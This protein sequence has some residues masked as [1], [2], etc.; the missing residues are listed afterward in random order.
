[1]TSRIFIINL[2][3]TYELIPDRTPEE[4]PKR[5]PVGFAVG[6]SG[7]FTQETS[8]RFP[9]RILEVAEG[10]LEVPRETT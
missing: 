2:D 9:E 3:K 5:T 4:I 6:S 1:M 8:G 7:K 10:T